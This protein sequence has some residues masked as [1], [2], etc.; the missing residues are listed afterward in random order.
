MGLFERIIGWS[1]NNPDKF[2]I[3]ILL[4][5]LAV[6]GFGVFVGLHFVIKYW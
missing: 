4:L 6:L 3:I 1:F 5:K 2:L